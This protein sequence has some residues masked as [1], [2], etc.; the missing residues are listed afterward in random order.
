LSLAA[1]GGILDAR[2][3]LALVR[4]EEHT[5]ELQSRSD[6]V[7]RLLLEKKNQSAG[8]VVWRDRLDRH[9]AGCAIIESRHAA[10]RRCSDRRDLCGADGFRIV[11]RTAADDA[12]SLAD[13]CRARDAR[14]RAGAADPARQPAAPA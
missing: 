7:C 13:D 2:H 4:S 1:G 6:L 11:E 10:D 8:A 5:S 14:L 12:Q 9:G 3:R